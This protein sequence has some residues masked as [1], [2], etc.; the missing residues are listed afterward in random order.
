MVVAVRTHPPL[1]ALLREVRDP[2]HGLQ[3]AL[4]PPR[5]FPPPLPDLERWGRWQP[6]PAPRGGKDHAVLRLVGACAH[7]AVVVAVYAAEGVLPAD[8]GLVV[9]PL[10][11]GDDGPVGAEGGELVLGGGD[12]AQVVVGQFGA[13]VPLLLLRQHPPPVPFAVVAAQVT[14]QAH[15]GGQ[16]TRSRPL[17]AITS[18]RFLAFP[19]EVVDSA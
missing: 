6:Q 14:E 1:R 8:A 5:I 3:V 11:G 10:G 19:N 12:V 15:L 4:A 2:Q 7:D 16:S 9:Q 17:P 13:A 18:V